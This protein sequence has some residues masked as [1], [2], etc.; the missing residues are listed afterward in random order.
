MNVAAS[1]RLAKDKNPERFCSNPRCLWR[2][3]RGD[4][5]ANPCRDHP[6]ATPAT[7]EHP[8]IARRSAA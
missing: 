4:G 1:V 3:V 6:A 2:I 7:R 8:E 5:S